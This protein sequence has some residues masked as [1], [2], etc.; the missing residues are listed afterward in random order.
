MNKSHHYRPLVYFSLAF[1]TTFAFWFAGAYVSF[2]A[3][4]QQ[5]PTL[6]G[7]QAERSRVFD[8]RCAPFYI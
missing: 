6:G 4:L 1:L 8:P 5:K 2:S 3:S 7:K